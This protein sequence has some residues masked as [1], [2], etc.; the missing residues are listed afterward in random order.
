MAI[1]TELAPSALTTL[2][3]QSSI[4]NNGSDPVSALTIQ[5][6]HNLQHQHLWTSLTTHKFTKDT[7]NRTSFSLLST[8]PSLPPTTTLISGIPPHRIYTHP[9]EQAYMLE[10]SIREEDLAPERM[11]VLPTAQGQSWSLRKL[12]TVFDSLPDLNDSCS[13]LIVEPSAVA[14]TYATGKNELEAPDRDGA[15]EDD[16]S[17][18]GKL[19]AYYERRRRANTS[20]EWGGKRLL[21]AMVDKGL[22]GDGTIVYYVIQD[23]I[24]KPRQN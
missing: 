20:H 14:M 1:N 13:P 7:T 5:V 4:G 2:I 10:M 12:A 15:I 17:K 24:I 9:E 21:L 23:G 3:T 18:A 22:G 6:L 11:F 19:A 8:T 16:K